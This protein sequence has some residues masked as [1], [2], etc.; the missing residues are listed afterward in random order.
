MQHDAKF[1]QSLV[2]S[3]DNNLALEA[4]SNRR[5]RKERVVFTNG[6]FDILHVGHIRY[7]KAAREL[8]ELLVIGLN[9]DDSVKRL[10]GPGR[11]I[12]PMDER[13]EVLEALKFVDYVLPFS[14]DTPLELIKQ[15]IPDVLVKGGDWPIEK[16]IGREVVEANRGKVT[17]IPFVE[18]KSSSNLLALLKKL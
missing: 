7:L 4:I 8:G 3:Y 10:K 13:K 14:E 18:G 11:P 12:V 1:R 5:Q 15:V 2:K 16:I 6:C 9:S 17:T